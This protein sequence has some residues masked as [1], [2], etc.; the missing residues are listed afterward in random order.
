M[1][2]NFAWL[3]DGRVLARLGARRAPRQRWLGTGIGQPW[4]HQA[5]AAELAHCRT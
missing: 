3:R 2:S 5:E 4:T 1:W